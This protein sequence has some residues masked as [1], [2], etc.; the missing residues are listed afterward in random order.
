[1]K[2]IRIFLLILLSVFSSSC[3]TTAVSEEVPAGAVKSREAISVDK[4]PVT[5]SST[6]D[7]PDYE[8]ADLSEDEVITEVVETVPPLS[9]T[10]FRRAIS[11]MMPWNMTAIKDGQIPLIITH[12]LDKNGYDD[13]LIVAVEGDDSADIQLDS[14]SQSSRLF[15]SKQQYS[16]FLLLIFY[17]YSS[18]VVL[19]YTVPVS[20]QIVFNGVEPIEI[21][22]DSD[23]PYALLFSFRTRAGIEQE[24]I[25]LSG[26]GIT[27]FTIM[28]NL[29]EIT[30]I[31]D[32]DDDGY[33]DIIVHEQGFEEGTGFENYL[34]WFKWNSRE[35]TEYRTTN[36]VRNLRQFFL[37]CAEYLRV[38]E[39]EAFLNYALDPEAL[40]E[41]K[42]Q[43]LNDS[44]ILDMI[45]IKADGPEAED[46]FF[47]GDGFKAVVFPEIMET[48]FSYAN[49]MDFRHQVSV[50]FRRSGG[51]SRI[52]WQ[53]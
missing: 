39:T 31:E 29:S 43:G 21:R 28:E 11:G 4:P 6:I 22:R 27:R 38:G 30:L 13:A 47:S 42:K 26:Y 7:L 24:L 3:L 5:S 40:S 9:V 1:M 48:S 12:D 37:V 23:F 2:S 25:I 32:I 51:D 50:R 20:R 49:R 46:G 52:F 34:T 45:F 16:N 33:Q 8:S 36:I 35:Y 15:Q 44:D 18:E 53:N 41:L 19:R 10:D 14:L 17:Q